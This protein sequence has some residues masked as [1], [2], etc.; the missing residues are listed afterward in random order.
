MTT[1]ITEVYDALKSVGVDEEKAR[2]AAE[3]MADHRDDINEIKYAIAAIKSELNV[4]R[5][6]LAINLGLFIPLFWKIF[7]L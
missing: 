5:W 4:I 2:K 1:M 3:A 7:S 6:M